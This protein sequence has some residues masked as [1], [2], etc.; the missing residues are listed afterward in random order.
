MGTHAHTRTRPRTHTP[1][2]RQ[3]GRQRRALSGLPSQGRR[4]EKF[5]CLCRTVFAKVLELLSW[6]ATGTFKKKKANPPA[7]GG[8]STREQSGARSA[9]S[10]SPKSSARRPPSR[11]Y[12]GGQPSVRSAPLAASPPARLPATITMIKCSPPPPPPP[13]CQRSDT[14]TRALNKQSRSGSGSQLLQA[15]RQTR[16]QGAKPGTDLLAGRNGHA[17]PPP[18]SP[19]RSPRLVTLGGGAGRPG[20]RREDPRGSWGCSQLLTCVCARAPA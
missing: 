1:Q 18:H 6:V 19:F 7:G 8:E 20:R 12:P 16:G 13:P 3:A 17:D 4:E 9:K 5:E 15:V 10:R 2:H 11:C 14:R